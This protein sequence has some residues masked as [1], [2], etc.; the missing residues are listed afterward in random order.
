MGYNRR[1]SH[2]KQQ[3]GD[4]GGSKKE[5]EAGHPQPE[6]FTVQKGQGQGQGQRDSR[7]KRARAR[8]RA[9]GIHGTTVQKGQEAVSRKQG[10]GGAP[11]E[12]SA[13]GA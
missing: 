5:A 13:R 6:G 9:R 11:V 8:A 12:C 3:A 1:C 10:A 2:H 7:Y 4:A